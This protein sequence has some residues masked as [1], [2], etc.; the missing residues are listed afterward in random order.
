M[1]VG[2]FR[3]IKHR[4]DAVGGLGW[5]VAVRANSRLRGNRA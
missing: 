3:E 1:S 2:M 4:E 5:N